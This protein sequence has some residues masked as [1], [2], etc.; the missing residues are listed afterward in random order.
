MYFCSGNAC[1]K[2]FEHVVVVGIKGIRYVKPGVA[3]TLRDTK[4]TANSVAVLVR[5]K[6]LKHSKEQSCSTLQSDY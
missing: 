2:S 3:H 6:C 4:L 1:S 5:C